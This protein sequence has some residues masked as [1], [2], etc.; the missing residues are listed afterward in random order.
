PEGI[1]NKLAEKNFEQEGVMMKM[2]KMNVPVFHMRR[3]LRW[4]SKYDLSLSLDT[5][6]VPGEGTVFSSTIHNVTIAT[7]CL[8][9]LLAA[10]IAVIIFDRHDRHFMANIVDTDDEL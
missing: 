10:I 4:A 6:P 9:I 1:N 7:I 5:K 8:I 2:A 3:I